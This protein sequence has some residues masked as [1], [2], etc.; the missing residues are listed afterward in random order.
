MLAEK[1][2][3]QLFADR[4]LLDQFKRNCS[5]SLNTMSKRTRVSNSSALGHG[6]SDPRR[7]RPRV[8]FARLNS[9]RSNVTEVWIAM[10]GSDELGHG[11]VVRVGLLVR[12]RESGVSQGDRFMNA[13]ALF[14]SVM[15][16]G[17][18]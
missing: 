2:G 3:Q 11:L 14:G 9:A 16:C 7:P 12:T 18:A 13:G 10:D 15:T 5:A 6:A 1:V 4:G 17:G 8:R